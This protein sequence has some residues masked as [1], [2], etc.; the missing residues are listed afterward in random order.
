SNEGVEFSLS[1]RNIQTDQFRWDTDFNIS[2]N[3]TNTER[4]NRGQEELLIDPSW[5][6]QF[7]QSEYQYVTRVGEPVGMMYGLEYD[8]LYQVSDFLLTPEGD[9]QLKEGLPSYRTA[10]RPG[11]VKF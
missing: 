6:A 8:G 5:D 11:M 4:L 9:Y 10:M 3:R 7:M 1:S 2:F